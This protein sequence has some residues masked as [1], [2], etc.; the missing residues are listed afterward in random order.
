MALTEAAP[1][2]AAPP[3]PIPVIDIAAFFTGTPEERR[4]VAEAVD[5]ACST[6]GFL[7]ITGHGIPQTS[8]DAIYDV[9]RDFFALPLEEKMK[10]V[11]TV[12]R[13]EGFTPNADP[14]QSDA[15][16]ARPVLRQ[17]YHS[18][19]YDTVDEAIAAG[20]P[21]GVRASLLSNLWPEAPA[22]FEATWKA[23]FGLMEELA[24]RLFH[25]FAVAL[26]LPETYFDDKVDQH[27]GTMA[28]NLY[29]EQPVAPVAGQLRTRAH[30]DFS[31]LTILYQD[32]APGGLQAY[33]RG[34]G[35]VDV[36][37][38][39]GSYVVNLGDLMGRW[40]N[41]RWVATPH[42]VVN[43]PA[44]HA[45]TRRISM[46]FFHLPNHDTVIDVLS[47]CVSEDRPVRFEPVMAGDWIE[48]RRVGGSA[49]YGR[50]QPAS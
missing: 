46:P 7:V 16:P 2:L 27:L 1:S 38:I 13:H 41:D 25:I 8:F 6:I 40:T 12:D 36:P 29:P 4:A 10:V 23:Y 45:M 31:T 21:E 34:H 49:N 3:S 33:H 43:P 44:E 20:Y 9:S 37:A 26:G 28:A 18:Y 32:D 47:T 14:P 5:A 50:I 24:G 48:A 39:A 15:G 17:Q 30:V 11:S 42:R 19:R 22:E 35:W